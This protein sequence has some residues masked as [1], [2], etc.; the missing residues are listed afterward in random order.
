MRTSE[1]LGSFQ[2]MPLRR[3]CDYALLKGEVEVSVCPV[4]GLHFGNS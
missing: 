2:Q 4:V 1:L 3:D